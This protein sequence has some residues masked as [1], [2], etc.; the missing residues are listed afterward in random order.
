MTAAAAVAI[1]RSKVVVVDD[2]IR[3]PYGGGTEPSVGKHPH[4]TPIHSPDSWGSDSD[5]PVT[6]QNDGRVAYG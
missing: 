2:F 1:R 3:S 5:R 6:R 4:R